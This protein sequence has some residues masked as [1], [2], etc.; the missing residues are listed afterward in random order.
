MRKHWFIALLGTALLAV[1]PVTA[2]A[3]GHHA[4]RHHRSRTHIRHITAANA[5]TSAT[6][7]TGTG[8]SSS[9]SSNAN[10]GRVTSF[11]GHRLVITLNDGSTVSGMVTNATALRC[12]SPGQFDEDSIS[13]NFRRADHGGQGSSGDGNPGGDPWSERSG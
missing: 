2:L 5:G 1:M 12:Q 10:A 4:K 8:S 9:P 6:T 3:H 7:P 11:D 13:S